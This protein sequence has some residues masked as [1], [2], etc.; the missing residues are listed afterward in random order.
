MPTQASRTN[1]FLQ[2]HTNTEKRRWKASEDDHKL[3][4]I[5]L[6]NPEANLNAQVMR[7]EKG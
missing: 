6:K 2:A 4:I 7:R 1:E 5:L 3:I